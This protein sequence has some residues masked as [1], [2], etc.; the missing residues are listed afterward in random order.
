MNNTIFFAA[1]AG[2]NGIA[3][4]LIELFNLIKFTS[5]GREKDVNDRTKHK[6]GR[7]DR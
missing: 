5:P 3:Y 4:M 6:K 1:L 2:C 7:E